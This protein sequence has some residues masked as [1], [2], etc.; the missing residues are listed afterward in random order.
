[1]HLN[2]NKLSLVTWHISA[3]LPG[4][5][6]LTGRTNVSAKNSITTNAGGFALEVGGVCVRRGS[7]AE[8]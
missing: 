4:K 8:I 6:Q 3:P 2:I 5:G 1:M 7:K